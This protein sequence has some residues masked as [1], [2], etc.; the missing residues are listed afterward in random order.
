M[1]DRARI[2]V[3]A[4]AGGDGV[5]ASA[6]RRTYPRAAPTAATAAAGA[7]SSSSATTRC[8]TSSA[9]ADARTSRRAGAV[10]AQGALRHGKDGQTLELRVPPGTEVSRGGWDP[11]RPGPPRP[12]GGG[13]PGRPGGRG[14]KRF[15]RPTH[16][17]PRF[18]ERGLPGDETWLTLQLK[19]LADVGLIGLP[20]AGKSSLLAAADPGPSEGRR[21]SVYDPRAG[22]RNPSERRSAARHRRHSRADRGRVRRGRA[23][24]RV[25][26]ARRAHPAARARARAR[27]ARRLGSGGQPRMVERELELHDSRLSASRECWRCRRRTWS[28]A[29]ARGGA[30]RWAAP[31]RGGARGHLGGDRLGSRMLT[32]E[33]LRRCRPARPSPGAPHSAPEGSLPST[34]SFGRP[35]SVAIE[36]E[37]DRRASFRGHRAGN[38]AP[39]RPLRPRERGRAGL[40]RAPAARDRRDRRA[41]RRKASRP[42]TRWKSPA[43]RSSS[44]RM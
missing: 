25:P 3:Q 5:S 30:A 18:A 8:A 34:G 11:A 36:V 12:A 17:T 16:Q 43:S 38:R 4:G 14:N 40:P 31:G 27:A 22:A 23:G 21:L 26:I 13:G 24:P 2:H 29:E 37:A 15:A 28:T 44:I 10:T 9:S 41:P 1:Q 6:A 7:T 20:N 19:L 33:L 42:G 32:D 35:P 39:G